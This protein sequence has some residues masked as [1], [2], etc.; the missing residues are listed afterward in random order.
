MSHR[1]QVHDME[2]SH[3][4]D[5][6]YLYMSFWQTGRLSLFILRDFP[7][8]AIGHMVTL[9]LR[10]RSMTSF[11]SSFT[12]RTENTCLSCIVGPFGAHTLTRAGESCDSESSWVPDGTEVFGSGIF[13]GRELHS[14]LGSLHSLK[15][16]SL[17]W[18]Y[19]QTETPGFVW[20]QWQKYPWNK[21]S[22]AGAQEDSRGKVKLW[23]AYS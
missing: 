11:S 13:Q 4:Y 21:L 2:H 3:L 19:L 12:L 1:I 16:C 22:K 9:S 18:V 8:W 17:G 20:L 14:L 7:V 5:Q 6:V 15:K 10:M 23:T